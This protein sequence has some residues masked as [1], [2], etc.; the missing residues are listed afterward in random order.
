MTSIMDNLWFC[1]FV[2]ICIL[3]LAFCVG[4]NIKHYWNHFKGD[5]HGGEDKSR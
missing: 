5:K 4:G 3:I 1:I 2:I